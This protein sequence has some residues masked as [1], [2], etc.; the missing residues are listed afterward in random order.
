MAFFNTKVQRRCTLLGT[1]MKRV[2]LRKT[3]VVADFLNT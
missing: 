1:R 2:C 3:L